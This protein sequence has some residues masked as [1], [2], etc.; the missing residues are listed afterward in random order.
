MLS[1]L[2][3]E[4]AILLVLLLLIVFT[5][6]ISGWLCLDSV[7]ILDEVKHVSFVPCP[8]FLV[9]LVLLLLLLLLLLLV[10]QVFL[11]VHLLITARVVGGLHL[12]CLKILFYPLPRGLSEMG[13]LRVHWLAKETA[14]HDL[15][16]LNG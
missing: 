4:P 9:L 8:R 13:R 1:I 7:V 14:F 10:V 11:L 12:I 15:E 5:L 3:V 6:T 16:V 2:A